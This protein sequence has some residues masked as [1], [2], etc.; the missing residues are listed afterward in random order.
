MGSPPVKVPGSH[1]V[2]T[3]APT[4]FAI[5]SSFIRDGPKRHPDRGLNKSTKPMA[6]DMSIPTVNGCDHTAPGPSTQTI[7]SGWDI[8]SYSSETETNPAKHEDNAARG[9]SKF[10]FNGEVV[11][12]KEPSR[13]T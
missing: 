13:S 8:C 9:S 6:N 2:K 1:P 11:R 7:N 12:A 10:T 3:P 5:Q 4:T